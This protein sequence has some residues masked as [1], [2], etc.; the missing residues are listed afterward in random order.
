MKDSIAELHKLITIPIVKVDFFPI[1][2]NILSIMKLTRTELIYKINGIRATS[3][4]VL[5][6]SSFLNSNTSTR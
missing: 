4:G 5:S 3:I 2:L 6:I 1:N